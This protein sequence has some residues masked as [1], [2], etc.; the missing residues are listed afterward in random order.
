MGH[1]VL[2]R[3]VD[4]QLVALRCMGDAWPRALLSPTPVP[5]GWIGLVVMPDGR[6]RLVPA[7]ED[8]RSERADTLVLIRSGPLVVSLRVDGVPAADGHPT[9][10]AVELALRCRTRDD[11]LAAFHKTLLTT[12]GLTAERLAE[13]VGQAGALAA[14]RRFVQQ[15]PAAR[16]VGDDQRDA[17]LA[18]LREELQGFL[19]AAGLTLDGVQHLSLTSASLAAEDALRRQTERQVREME[20]RGV[21]EQAALAATH[22]RLDHLGDI[23]GKLKTAAHADGTLK[24]RDLLP[25]LT[26]GERGRLLESL[27]RLT[28]DRATAAAIV[29]VAG[30]ECV[31]L[32][33]RQP[34]QIGRRVALPDELGGLRSVS[35]DAAG[36]ELLVGAARGIWRL[37][38]ADGGIVQQY[39][40]PDAGTPRT[41]FNAAA[42]SGDR[43]FATH[44]QLGAWSWS[45]ADP[46]DAQALLRPEAG[47]PGTIRAATVDAEGR[48]WLGADNRARAYAASGELCAESGPADGA[49]HCL[50]ALEDNLFAGTETGALLRCVL[51]APS[52]WTLVHRATRAIE[53]ITARRWDD[54][55]E[56]VIPAGAQGVCGVYLSEG[57]VA[58]LLEAPTA[59]RRAWACDDALVGLSDG[60]DRLVV[61][62]ATMPR[63]GRDVPLARMLRSAVQDACIVTERRGEGSRDQGIE[64]SRDQGIE[65]SRDQGTEGSG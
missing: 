20:A 37:R 6:R 35:F 52:G 44:S 31:W 64:G 59:I 22:R 15:Q 10:A 42:I 39:A 53:S 58:R 65:G 60:R 2:E 17:V 34:D 13:A 9:S 41:G 16:L 40:V 25:T 32:D 43:L 19:F 29:A 54:L 3:L 63:T 23:L 61:L 46:A 38:A 28:P 57:I 47:V 30:R 18:L 14:L 12:A 33:P 8:P 48:I 45:L 5:A 56:L 51:A 50:T 4:P 36:G 55:V 11:E 26:P 7:G 27:W 21:V 49:I 62:H 1:N 24:W